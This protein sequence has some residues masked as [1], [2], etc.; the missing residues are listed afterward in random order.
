L[1]P[2][3]GLYEEARRK[4]SW[5]YWLPSPQTRSTVMAPSRAAARTAETSTGA[6][7]QAAWR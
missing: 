7:S 1:S 2:I 6:P 3:P 5:V 4:R